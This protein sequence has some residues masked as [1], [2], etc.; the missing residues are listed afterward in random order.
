MT[1]FLKSYVK[2]KLSAIKDYDQLRFRPNNSDLFI[3]E[4]PK[5]GIT[6]F[7]TIIANT[8]MLVDEERRFATH[9]NL[10]QCGGARG[11]IPTR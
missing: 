4:F 10:E 2:K 7:S 1:V 5:S 3:V 8:M 6:W 9:F 11:P